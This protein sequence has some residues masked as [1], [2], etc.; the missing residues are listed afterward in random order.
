M[1]GEPTV[2]VEEIQAPEMTTNSV[3]PSDRVSWSVKTL[4]AELILCPRAH[5]A[6]RMGGR[7]QV[8]A[9]IDHTEAPCLGPDTAFQKG[10]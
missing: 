4:E 10:R 2:A 3:R 9:G 6:R 7:A 5:R 8:H 1:K